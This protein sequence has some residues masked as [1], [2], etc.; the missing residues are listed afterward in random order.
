MAAG[1][2]CA[3]GGG[4]A[5]GRWVQPRATIDADIN[6]FAAPARYEEA[7]AALT[8]IGA[9][10]DRDECLRRFARG[11]V[12]FARLD[13]IRVD[14]FVPSIPFYEEAERTIVYTTIDGRVIPFLSPESLAVFKLLFFR[15]KDI[16]DLRKMVQE[17]GG[18]LDTSWVREHVVAMMGEAD[19]RISRWDE[20][21]GSP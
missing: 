20:I 6:V 2:S 21:V 5:F 15:P 13:G 19:E 9:V 14:L 16:V 10:L 4:L 8:S 18:S 12:A 7:L 3:I 11:D 17:L 1:I